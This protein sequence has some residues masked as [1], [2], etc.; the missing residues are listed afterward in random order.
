MDEQK[1]R[2]R[3]EPKAGKVGVMVRHRGETDRLNSWQLTMIGVGGIIGAGFFL[4]SGI[5]IRLSG[6][7]VLINYLIGGFIMTQVFFALAEMSV[8]YPVSGSFRVYAEKALGSMAGFMSGWIYWTAGVLIM[9][10]EVTASAIFTSY[11]FPQVPL[12]V[13]TL[14]YSAAIIG[15]NSLGIKEFGT[16][17][18]WFSMIKV[19]ALVTFIVLGLLVMAGAV[20]GVPARGFHNYTAAGGVFPHGIRGLLASS[21]MVL[22]S[23]GGAEVTG[24]ASSSAENPEK[25]VPEAI[26]N[27]V[28]ILLVLYIGSLAVLLAIVPWNTIN[29]KASPFVALFKHANFPYAGSVMNFIILTAALSTMN[30]AMYGVTQVLFSLGQG[31]FAPSMLAKTNRRGVAVNALAASSIG[32]A[33]AVLLAYLLPGR[34]YE[35]ITSA[36]GFMQFSNWIIILLTQ[37]YYRPKLEKMVQGGLKLKMWGYPF[38]SWLTVGLL[39]VVLLTTLLSPGQRVGFFTGTGIILALAAAY[40]LTRHMM[41]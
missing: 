16:I 29:A 22:L 2:S 23:F 15:V 8:A 27:I 14:V 5:A 34:V 38:T 18:S 3:I 11:W 20:Y 28:S 21:M 37:I 39:T 33:V 32:L 30:A 40:R 17:E 25:T 10:S 36:A 12:W 19:G 13:T 9:S 24:M 41:V 1:I 35:Y 7:A 26:F 31:R 4:A 6:P